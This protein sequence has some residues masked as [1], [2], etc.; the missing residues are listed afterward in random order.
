MGQG[1]SVREKKGAL[2]GGGQP[3]PWKGPGPEKRHRTTENPTEIKDPRS[4]AGDRE[5][6]ERQGGW[7]QRLPRVP[8][9]KENFGPKAVLRFR[10]RKNGEKTF[11]HRK[12][13]RDACKGPPVVQGESRRIINTGGRRFKTEVE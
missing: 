7:I 6:L 2:Q 3:V 12:G 11:F 13:G 8:T 4:N 9:G 10:R 1:R 5:N